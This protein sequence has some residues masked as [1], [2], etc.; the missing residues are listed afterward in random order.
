M[1]GKKRAAAAVITESVAQAALRRGSVSALEAEEEKV[2]RMRLGATLPLSAF[3]LAD[4]V[5]LG[6]IAYDVALHRRLHPAYLWAGLLFV[7]AFPLRLP[8]S[9]T[10]AWLAFAN[11]LA[12]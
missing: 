4:V 5:L 6:C 7:L 12:R 8:L 9:G 3:G 10:S 11:W 1:Q 2:M